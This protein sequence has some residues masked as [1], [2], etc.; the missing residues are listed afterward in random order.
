MNDHRDNI[1]VV[2]LPYQNLEKKILHSHFVLNFEKFMENDM[3][4]PIIQCYTFNQGT[5]FA[6]KF[7]A[8]DSIKTT[9]RDMHYST[10]CVI[11]P[12]GGS[13]N[14]V[15]FSKLQDRI[16]L[17]QNNI[18][19]HEF[20][21]HFNPFYKM[22]GNQYPF[23]FFKAAVDVAFIGGSIKGIINNDFAGVF[24]SCAVGGLWDYFKDVRISNAQN[25]IN[26]LE[27][28]SQMEDIF[29]RNLSK[30][31]VKVNYFPEAEEEIYKL[32]TVHTDNPGKDL[33]LSEVNNRLMKI[34]GLNDDFL[35]NSSI[36]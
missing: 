10:L 29:Q 6:N 30:S 35:N 11:P 21:N 4:T 8:P 5:E 22:K 36:L 24:L 20:V 23:I 15:E 28:Y 33:D 13:N 19:D 27:C 25:C 31:K 17:E 7:Y 14:E 34:Y 2:S 3:D 26:V 9:L 16:T 32:L 12:Y 18:E 1:Q